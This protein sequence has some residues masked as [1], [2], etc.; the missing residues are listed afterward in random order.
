MKVLRL[1]VII[2]A[3]HGE[4]WAQEPT[5]PRPSG[6]QIDPTENVKALTAAG[7][8][9]QDDLRQADEKLIA[10]KIEAE[11]K[12]SDLKYQHA[13][14]TAKALSDKME[15]KAQLRA[16]LDAKLASAEKDRLN[17]IRS[18]DVAQA[19][20]QIRR[21]SEQATTLQAQTTSLA[22]TLQKQT[23]SIANDLRTQI[24][25]KAAAA[26]QSEQQQFGEIGKRLTTLEQAQSEG[27][28]KQAYQDPALAT[29]T[30]Q[31]AQILRQQETSAGVGT[32][33]NDVTGWVVGVIMLLIG[34]GG[35]FVNYTK[36]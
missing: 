9:A 17:A 36:K 11:A 31:V 3:L 35:V 14:D 25:T 27:R 5:P 8:K 10:V 22:D 29:L 18:V 23:S 33:R 21:A 16:E 28:G 13:V 1:L 20:E 15:E 6:G 2:G 7:L 24:D 4:A 12:I 30:V 26:L 32:G 34:L 19:A